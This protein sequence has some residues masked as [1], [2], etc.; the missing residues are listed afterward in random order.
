MTDDSVRVL[1]RKWV[2]NNPT[3]KGLYAIV[4]N[5][6]PS[7]EVGPTTDGLLQMHATLE[8]ANKELEMVKKEV[9]E[10]G[11]F[12][13]SMIDWLNDE[14]NNNMTVEER[15]DAGR[16]V[17]EDAVI[18]ERVDEIVEGR[19]DMAKRLLS[20]YRNNVFTLNPDMGLGDVRNRTVPE[21]I[22]SWLEDE[23][24]DDW[25]TDFEYGG[26]EAAESLLSKIEEWEKEL[27]DEYAIG[28]FLNREN[29]V[30]E[31]DSRVE[32]LLLP[33]GQVI[34]ISIPSNKG[35]L[36][37]SDAYMKP[38]T[39]AMLDEQPFTNPAIQIGSKSTI[40][41]DHKLNRDEVFGNRRTPFP[42]IMISN[43]HSFI[44]TKN[45]RKNPLKFNSKTTFQFSRNY[46]IDTGTGK[47]M[48]VRYVS[49][50]AGEGLVIWKDKKFARKAAKEARK[51]GY[52]I[53]T[54]P[55][56]GG[57]VNLAARRQHWP[58]YH[59]RY[60]EANRDYL[61][62]KGIEMFKRIRDG[63]IKGRKTDEI[64]KRR[65]PSNLKSYWY[66]KG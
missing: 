16:V 25:Q 8:E 64:N 53:R 21:K 52:L 5:P 59:P 65:F 40:K 24:I 39:K 35:N 10:Y 45:N 33:D 34:E 31:N 41:W 58:E 61:E 27:T 14:I 22:K 18:R 32:G 50:K 17:A 3:A 29:A 9:I 23:V 56:S 11:D 4:V 47:K 66:R 19:T 55:V 1:L 57:F 20:A 38:P 46:K 12:T 54:I 42:E 6:G 2:K 49:R 28:N 30:I 36:L 51:R 44:P 60:S 63:S 15:L 48:N 26:V 13:S 43:E 62:S 37:D 7:S